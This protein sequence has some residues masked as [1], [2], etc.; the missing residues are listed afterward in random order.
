MQAMGL[1]RPSGRGKRIDNGRFKKSGRKCP[2]AQYAGAAGPDAP[3]HAALCADGGDILPAV[4][5][6]RRRIFPLRGRFQQPADQLLPLHER[7]HQ[8]GRL[9]GRHGRR[10][11]QH[12][13]LGHRPGQRRDE[14][15]LVLPVRFALLLAVPHLPPELAA[16]PHGAAA[17]A[18]ICRGGRRRLPLPL[19]LCPPLRPRGAGCLPVCLLGFQHLQCLLQPLYRRGGPLPVDALGAG[20]NAL[21]AGRALR[22]LRV[23]GGRQSAQQLLLLHRT[24]PLPRHLLHLQADDER[25]PDE[26]P[27]LRPAGL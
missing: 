22:P 3:H 8:G 21:R 12:L 17:G 1:C 16:L 25:F 11:P 14:R 20:R 24:G 27:P 5:Y 9:P 4:L 7:L 18:E 23:L 26:C 10:G 15:L 2:A 6:H 19:P 13:L